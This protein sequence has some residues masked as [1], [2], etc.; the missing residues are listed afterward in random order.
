M[1]VGL[2]TDDSLR[3]DVEREIN[4]AH[5]LLHEINAEVSRRHTVRVV[6]W[7]VFLVV[8]TMIA[9]AAYDVEWARGCRAAG[10]V[11]LGDCP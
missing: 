1:N 8:C 9:A 5:D 6:F 10:Y 2:F 11:R 3:T 4:R 7:C